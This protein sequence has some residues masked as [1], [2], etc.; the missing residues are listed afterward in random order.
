M[1]RG[2]YLVR[3]GQSMSNL[4]HPTIKNSPLTTLGKTQ[5]KRLQYRTDLLI[6]SPL[7]RALDTLAYSNIKYN[8]LFIMS[9]ARELICEPGDCFAW[10]NLQVEDAITFNR[11]MRAFA[12][13]IYLLA[14]KS[15]SITIVTHGCVITA[16]TGKQIKNCEVE[17]ISQDRL[18]HIINGVQLCT[19]YHEMTGW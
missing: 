13:K 19:N 3:H 2:I 17:S 15:P 18:K 1:L 7:A 12:N 14:Q 11:T 5:A 16:L 6:C 10:E 4:G 8:R 9:M